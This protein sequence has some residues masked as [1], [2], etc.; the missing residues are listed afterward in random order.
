MKQTFEY[1]DNC[2]YALLE[3][4]FVPDFRKGMWDFVWQY[5]LTSERQILIVFTV[6]YLIDEERGFISI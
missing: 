3:H 5:L 2:Y 4:R 1:L 6:F